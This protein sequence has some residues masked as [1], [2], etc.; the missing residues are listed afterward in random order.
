MKSE[1]LVIADQH[2]AV[3]TFPG[4]AHTA[5][6]RRAESETRRDEMGLSPALSPVCLGS[7]TQMNRRGPAQAVEHVV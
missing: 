6:E 3:N 4:L 7:Q 1:S 2:A 5:R